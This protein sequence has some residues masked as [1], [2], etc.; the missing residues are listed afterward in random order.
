MPQRSQGRDRPSVYEVAQRAGVS[1]ATVSRVLRRSAPVAEA[2]RDRVLAAA[3]EL[4]WRPSRL[5]RAFVEQSHGAVGIV[6]P[7]LGG[8]YYPRVIAG[9]ESAAAERGVAVLIAATHGRQNAPELVAEL[10]ERVDGIVV[11]GSTVDDGVVAALDDAQRPVV[12]LARPP[13]GGLPAARAAN[14]GP[15]VELA[16]HVVG[17]GRRRI[18]FVGD[19][20]S[21]PDVAER[22]R[23]V[24]RVLRSEG[25]DTSTALVPVDGFDLGRGFKAGLDLFTSQPDTDA[26][27]CANDELASGVLRAAVA[28]GRRVPRDVVITGWDDSP[29]AV[30]LQPPL[31]TVHQPMHELGARAVRMLFDRLDGEAVKSVV[32]PAS[33]VVR[34]SCGCPAPAAG[35]RS[36]STTRGGRR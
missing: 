10:A 24:R 28:S 4:Q 14:V 32:L 33:L 29:H 11:T 26:V 36:H 8:P 13:F 34:G 18:V 5:A 20:R 6:F 23:G 16:G 30:A 9:F 7:D 12:L 35:T 21:S 27:V 22:W 2:T 31:T 3:E 15:A 17:H 19:P 25:I 1:I